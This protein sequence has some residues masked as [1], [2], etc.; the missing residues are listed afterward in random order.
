MTDATK[1]LL[2]KTGENMTVDDLDKV[3][4]IHRLNRLDE[5]RKSLAQKLAE[6]GELTVE[7]KDSLDA[8]LKEAE[9]VDSKGDDAAQK[10]LDEK[11]VRIKK[12]ISVYEDHDNISNLIGVVDVKV[13]H[14][15]F[16]GC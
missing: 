11:L 16:F 10:V 7:K 3:L 1:P 8:E 5:I 4:I 12:D 14:L 9:G 13:Q 6:L 15:K 2:P